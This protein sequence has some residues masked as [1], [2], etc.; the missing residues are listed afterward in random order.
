M[1]TLI[2]LFLLSPSLWAADGFLAISNGVTKGALSGGG[3]GSQ[4]PWL[5]DINGGGFSLTNATV[6]TPSIYGYVDAQTNSWTTNTAI[7]LG[8]TNLI[9]LSAANASCGI[10]GVANTPSTTTRYCELTII[11]TGDVVFTN[12]PAIHFSDGLTSRTITNSTSAEISVKVF[13]G[14]RT[15]AAISYYP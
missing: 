1:K 13:P 8:F 4:T 2:F 12:I 10:T 9:L 3:S 11:V 7:P 6:T 15:N 5:S 14:Q